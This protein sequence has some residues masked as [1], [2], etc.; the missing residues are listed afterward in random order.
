MESESGELESKRNIDFIPVL[1]FPLTV[2]II[3]DDSS[4]SLVHNE[5]DAASLAQAYR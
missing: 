5:E 3:I 2:V 1:F 4:P